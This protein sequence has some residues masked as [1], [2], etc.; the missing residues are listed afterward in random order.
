M[1]AENKT[2]KIFYFFILLL[3]ISACQKTKPRYAYF[4]FSDN[5]LE[6]I[7]ING[8]TNDNLENGI[9]SIYDGKANSLIKQGEYE[10]GLKN[11]SWIYN[12][13]GVEKTVDWKI[14]SE[15]KKKLKIN[16][17]SD[18]EVIDY[19][20]M[21]FTATFKSLSA[22]TKNK[23]FA[24]LKH[25]LDSAIQS[26]DDYH[27]MSLTELKNKYD[28]IHSDFFTIKNG[29]EVHYLTI[30]FV[31]TEGE[32]IMLLNFLTIIDNQLYDFIYSSLNEDV[33]LKKSLFSDVILGCFIK[34]RRV[35]DPFKDF[36]ISGKKL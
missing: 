7:K 6:E 17:P 33:E 31:E 25:P 35:L 14:I 9:W 34:N 23:Y 19:D 3:I 5:I 11:G 20:E 27:T 32:Q 13:K 26:M 29:N 21:Y 30:Y 16:L 36:V 24:I 10:D 8:E 28:L 4:N 1:N 15:S 12:Q 2:S 22:I 18:W